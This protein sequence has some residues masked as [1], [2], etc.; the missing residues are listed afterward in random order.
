MANFILLAFVSFCVILC[1]GLDYFLRA[2][3]GNYYYRNFLLNCKLRATVRCS[4]HLLTKKQ[5]LITSAVCADPA[6]IRHTLR[7]PYNMCM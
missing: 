3:T 5:S 6:A 4:G 1:G 2:D 7:V